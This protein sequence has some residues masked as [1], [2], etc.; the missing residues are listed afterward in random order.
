MAS[1]DV[2]RREG[3]AGAF[4]GTKCSGV[5]LGMLDEISEQKS[6]VVIPCHT[7]KKNEN[8]IIDL[9][10]I[11]ESF[12]NN[13]EGIYFLNKVNETHEYTC[14]EINFNKTEYLMKIY[15]NP[16]F[17][18]NEKVKSNSEIELC[19]YIQNL[20]TITTENNSTG[21]NINTDLFVKL[22]AFG[23]IYYYT[24]N[25]KKYE[26]FTCVNSHE[27][28]IS[29]KCKPIKSITNT[30]N[31]VQVIGKLCISVINLHEKGLTLGYPRLTTL[32]INKN[33]FSRW[34]LSSMYLQK[35]S[36]GSGTAKLMANILRSMDLCN[37]LFYNEYFFTKSDTNADR[38]NEIDMVDIMKGLGTNE[39]IHKILIPCLSVLNRC[40]EMIN[41]NSTLS[42]FQE[43]YTNQYKSENFNDFLRKI[44][45]INWN[46]IL[47][48]F[49]DY[50][51]I[52]N[53]YRI[54]I[55]IQKEKAEYK[56]KYKETV[57]DETKVLIPVQ[58]YG[59]D[60]Y[61]DISDFEGQLSSDPNNVHLRKLMFKPKTGSDSEIIFYYCGK[62][63]KCHKISKSDMEKKSFIY[64]ENGVKIEEQGDHSNNLMFEIHNDIINVCSYNSRTGIFKYIAE[65]KF[66]GS[67]QKESPIIITENSRQTYEDYK[68]VSDHNETYYNNQ[69]QPQYSSQPTQHPTQDKTSPHYQTSYQFSPS[70]IIRPAYQ[71]LITPLII[72]GH[73]IQ[74]NVNNVIR[75]LFFRFEING[76]LQLYII[77]EKN[78]DGTPKSYTNINALFPLD[79]FVD[80]I[81]SGNAFSI[82]L[83]KGI[84][85][86]KKTPLGYQLQSIEKI[87]IYS[88][89]I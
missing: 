25:E 16:L 63:T 45:N 14:Y 65:Y 55:A 33:N 66:E 38:L 8:V 87:V 72:W 56:E 15:H 20:K 88:H 40:E 80:G 30:D 1:R 73:H 69:W 77:N 78:Q 70:D 7:N 28:I 18:K 58:Q 41:Y 12:G 68:T 9:K 82:D 62:D 59:K 27:V 74:I 44:Y 71:G 24:D 22:Y 75:R 5:F 39:E 47:L 57:N 89:T 64:N 81:A 35:I 83:T 60:V 53:F 6:R 11:D 26:K 86:Y 10:I 50:K 48:F 4:L 21:G 51:K 37:I 61:I 52:Q 23:R 54:A 67:L 3:G 36:Y 46:D 19:R 79:F 32:R 13:T 31:F 43:E 34:V 84:L 85:V 76:N 17:I 2:R 29:E 42:I 49:K